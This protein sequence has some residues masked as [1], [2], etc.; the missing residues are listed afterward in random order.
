MSDISQLKENLISLNTLH[1]NEFGYKIKEDYIR[2]SKG[3]LIVMKRIRSARNI[4]KLI[5]NTTIGGAA[6]VK[7]DQDSQHREV[8]ALVGFDQCL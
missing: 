5:A 1:V 3:A 2:V 4:H 8:Q 6:V 7:S